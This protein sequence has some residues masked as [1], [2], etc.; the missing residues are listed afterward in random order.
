MTENIFE[1]S[2][3][4]LFKTKNYFRNLDKQI[5][6]S[7]ALLLILGLF[8]SFSS[9]SFLADESLN[10]E[11]FYEHAKHHEI[12]KSLKL[13]DQPKSPTANNKTVIKKI[14]K[15]ASSSQKKKERFFKVYKDSVVLYIQTG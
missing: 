1:K 4:S 8:F 12:V 2:K 7:F 15:E 6:L 14:I 13:K 3:L 9:T 10:K 5:L 11:I